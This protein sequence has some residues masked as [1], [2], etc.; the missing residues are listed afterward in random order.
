MFMMLAVNIGNPVILQSFSS[1]ENER[2]VYVVTDNEGG[3]SSSSVESKSVNE[4][5]MTETTRYYYDT[6][7]WGVDEID[8][9]KVWGGEEGD[10]DITSG[11][12]YYTGAGVKLCVIDSG[13][14]TDH[15]D[16]ASNYQGGWD[17][18][19]N[20]NDPSDTFGHGTACAGIIAAEDNNLGI[21]GV[22][23]EVDLY[24]ARN[25]ATYPSITITDDAIDWAVENGIQIISMSLGDVNTMPFVENSCRKAVQNG[26]IVIAAT[27]NDGASSASYPAQ[28]Y[29]VIGVGAAVLD[30]Y[31]N[32]KFIL[33][34]DTN[35]GTGLELLAPGG[36]NIYT[37]NISNG[38]QNFGATSAA[39]PHVAG[40]CALILEANPNLY[41]GEVR[42]IL[43]KSARTDC[44]S[45]GL[46]PFKTYYGEGLVNAE[47]AI[48]YTLN[49]YQRSDTD[50]DGLY[51]AEEEVW[52]TDPEDTDS[53]DD[54]MPD[55]WEVQYGLNPTVDDSLG[56]LDSDGLTNLQEYTLGTI[57]TTSDTDGDSMP[58]GWEVNQNFNP[59][60][61]TD[62]VAD[63]DED[64]LRNFEEYNEGTNPHD[65]DTDDDGLSDNVEVNWGTNPLVDDV[66]ADID[67][68][69]LTNYEEIMGVYDFNGDGD[70]DDPGEYHGYH[71]EPTQF[72]TDGDGYGDGYEIDPNLPYDPSD[73]TDPNSIPSVG[74]GGGGGFF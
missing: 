49:T 40:I 65:E 73:P 6:L 5:D 38:Y 59:L 51:D 35:Y 61:S 48:Y 26:V 7:D 28:Y 45:D 57:P 1:T 64:G 4:L 42:Y 32:S 74:G 17:F 69:G 44:F 53:D 27:G 58:D 36:E 43:Q 21:I 30:P 19:S 52:G 68:D 24:V 15:D 56:D 60:N 2:V 22:A 55:G 11:S 62:G 37:T 34:D 71:T 31:D 66:D 20:D 72:D 47:A 18:Y 63:A 41:A 12:S 25:G 9:E 39:A 3:F 70:Y 23:P 67:S 10:T 50:N 33:W 29:S 8:A 54:G 14:D 13:I 16:L 46:T